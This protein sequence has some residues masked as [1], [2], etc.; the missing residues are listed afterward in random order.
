MV[1]I[2]LRVQEQVNRAIPLVRLLRTRSGTRRELLASDGFEVRGHHAYSVTAGGDNHMPVRHSA[3][4][5]DETRPVGGQH[6]PS[7]AKPAIALSVRRSLPK[8]MLAVSLYVR[9]EVCYQWPF[10]HCRFLQRMRCRVPQVPHRA[11]LN[12]RI[13]HTKSTP[14]HR[15]LSCHPGA[16]IPTTSAWVKPYTRLKKP[17]LTKGGTRVDNPR[18]LPLYHEDSRLSRRSLLVQFFH[19]VEAMQ[20]STTDVPS[21]GGLARVSPEG[22]SASVV[23]SRYPASAVEAQRLTLFIRHRFIRSHHCSPRRAV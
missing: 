5:K 20:G 4:L 9:E 23:G 8:Q 10:L 19:L 16:V 18:M 11:S 6:A 3:V 22:A 15:F 17:H 12:R 14:K 2:F 7:D 1:A 21:G 13:G